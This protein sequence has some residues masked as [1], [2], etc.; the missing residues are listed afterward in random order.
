M[1]IYLANDTVSY[2]YLRIVGYLFQPQRITHSVKVLLLFDRLM[3]LQSVA[4][5]FIAVNMRSLPILLLISIF[6]PHIELN[7]K[8]SIFF[9]IFL[10]TF[11]ILLHTHT[12]FSL[13]HGFPS[14]SELSCGQTSGQYCNP[15]GPQSGP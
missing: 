6:F 5:F 10:L 13:F 15:I 14:H 7:I 9:Y 12:D 1:L 11:L 4:Q 8:N 2:R 3:L